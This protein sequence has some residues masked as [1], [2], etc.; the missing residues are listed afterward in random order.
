M[1]DLPTIVQRVH[2]CSL[3]L[4]RMPPDR[5]LSSYP[6]VAPLAACAR[7]CNPHACHSSYLPLV[8]CRLRVLVVA[9]SMPCL[10]VRVFS[11]HVPSFLVF[12]ASLVASLIASLVAFLTT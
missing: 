7:R 2:S 11:C 3:R 6:L 8:A 12:I 5:A 4:C 9:P 1:Y 10:L